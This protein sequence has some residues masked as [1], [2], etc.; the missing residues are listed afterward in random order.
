MVEL[1]IIHASS[2]V[3]SQ[4]KNRY[5]NLPE[6]RLGERRPNVAG[7][8]CNLVDA[9][10]HR[11]VGLRARD[12]LPRSLQ[13]HLRNLR[14]LPRSAW[15]LAAGTL[16]AGRVRQGKPLLSGLH[17]S[18]ALG[19]KP[20]EQKR[21]WKYTARRFTHTAI[22]K[23]P[24]AVCHAPSE[25]LAQDLPLCRAATPSCYRADMQFLGGCMCNSES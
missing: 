9:H 19:G 16:G 8:V 1:T 5:L 21:L 25:D 14:N 23:T 12:V 24:H 4:R 13:L 20:D 22:T 7:L 15:L 6:F 3:K 18:G 2:I 10:V 11:R 17:C